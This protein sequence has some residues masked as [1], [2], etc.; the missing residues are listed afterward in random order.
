[1]FTTKWDES[2]NVKGSENKIVRRSGGYI[3]IKR[4]LKNA[5]SVKFPLFL[6]SSITDTATRY[7]ERVKKTSTPINPPGRMSRKKW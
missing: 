5:K 3:L 1:M 2:N 4:R 7:P 6:N